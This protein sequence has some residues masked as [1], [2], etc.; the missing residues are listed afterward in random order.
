MSNDIESILKATIQTKVVEAFNQTPE[1][2]DKLVEAA[3]S[4]EVD[5]HGSKPS[6]Y[7]C[8]KMPYM[9]WLVGEEIRKAI[10][11]SV[12]EYVS[13]HNNEIREKVSDSI[14]KAEYG[15]ALAETLTK[16]LSDEWRWSVDLK[17]RED[18]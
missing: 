13:Q 2:I 5:E 3:M 8:K 15:N 10:A 7:G 12:H 9:E 16:I 1:M 6:S 18:K 11:A 14:A 4:K 17:V